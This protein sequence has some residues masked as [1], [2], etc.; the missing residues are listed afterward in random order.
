MQKTLIL[1]LATGLA[2]CVISQ[3]T[4]AQDTQNWQLQHLPEG[5]KARFGKG[6]ITGNFANSND[7]KRLAVTCAIGIWI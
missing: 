3:N 5:A 1:I 6:M 2:L 7:G 4:I